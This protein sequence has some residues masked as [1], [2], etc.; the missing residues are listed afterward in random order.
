MAFESDYWHALDARREMADEVGLSLKDIGISHG[1]GDVLDGLKANVFAGGSHVE[2]GFTGTGKGSI[3]GQSTNPEMFGTD[4]REA[5]RQLS[6]INEMTV[7]THASVAVQGFAGLTREGFSDRAAEASLNEVRRAIEFAADAA[8]G[9]AVA[10][11]TGEFPTEIAEK[12]KEFEEFPSG[13]KQR[14]EIVTLVDKETGQLV[15]FQKGTVLHEPVW[16][17]NDK[18]KFINEFGKPLNEDDYANRVPEV[19][20]KGEVKFNRIEWADIE[21]KTKEYNKRNPDK[22]LSPGQMF[23]YEMHRAELERA[24]PFASHYYDTYERMIRNEKELTEKYEEISELEKAT[25]KHN[26]EKLRRLLINELQQTRIFDPREMD[27]K[28]SVAEQLKKKIDEMHRL[29]LHEKESAIGYSKQI[30]Q[31]EQMKQ[32]I[33][34]VEGFGKQKS[35][36]NI[37]KL[38][39]YAYD[40]EKSRKTSKPIVIA[41]ENIFPETGY[42][43]HP[44]EL[45]EL[46]VGS[47]KDMVEALKARH[48]SETEAKKI[49][50]EHIK[51][52]FDV[53]HANTWR[54]FFKWKEG[55]TPE[56]HNKRFNEWLIKEVKNLN[57]EGIIGHIHLSDNFGYFDEHLTPGQGNTPLKEFVKEMKKSGFKG[58]MVAEPGAQGQGFIHEAM[59]GAWE[60]LA[61]SPIYRTSKWTDVQDS[62][63]GQTM[64]PVR[65]VGKY[66]PSQ[67]YLGIEKGAPFWSGIGLE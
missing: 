23:V 2:L 29:A 62:Y 33:V 19:D 36:H 60:H 54:K 14:E 35:T 13:K 39:M 6:K 7:S 48:I 47:R 49:A 41:P 3:G 53:A 58:E 34:P 18:G 37:A 28:K 30:E 66:V 56:S 21:N 43:A 26:Q 55:E 51:A 8:D 44:Q 27:V 22:Q 12:Y 50:E 25:P 46:I 61:T 5:I 11:H 10:I 16:K 42:G 1:M 9:G 24:R 32:K 63:F 67:E 38:A 20:E 40:I 64:S 57:K 15:R 4:K 65:I 59:T 17:K 52:T 31:I 45:K